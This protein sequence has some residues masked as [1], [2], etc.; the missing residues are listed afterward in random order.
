[1]VRG[2]VVVAAGYM[3]ACADVLIINHDHRDVVCYLLAWCLHCLL[4]NCIVLFQFELQ[5]SY[6]YHTLKRIIISDNNTIPR[7]NAVENG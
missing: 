3:R 2:A 5:L 1:M 4:A 7:H 6:Y